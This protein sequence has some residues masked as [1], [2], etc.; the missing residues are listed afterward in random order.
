MQMLRL[1]SRVEETVLLVLRDMARFSDAS[2][3]LAALRLLDIAEKPQHPCLEIYPTPN[4][5]S[6]LTRIASGRHLAEEWASEHSSI[7]WQAFERAKAFYED[8]GARATP[9]ENLTP[10]A[11]LTQMKLHSAANKHWHEWSAEWRWYWVKTVVP[12]ICERDKNVWGPRLESLLRGMPHVVLK[13]A[14]RM[15][16]GADVETQIWWVSRVVFE[17]AA[18]DRVEPISQ[19]DVIAILREEGQAY[20][21]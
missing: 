5:V 2:L 1:S 20:G 19:P 4:A 10:L 18:L 12:L 7:D 11:S 13:I 15:V 3:T 14:M 9:P 16:R 21:M 8:W 17:R 6:A